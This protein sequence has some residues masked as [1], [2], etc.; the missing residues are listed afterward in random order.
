LFLAPRG[1]RA[2][3]ASCHIGLEQ[4]QAAFAES[5]P[6]L[7]LLR[8]SARHVFGQTVGCDPAPYLLPPMRAHGVTIDFMAKL[9]RQA[10]DA[11]AIDPVQDGT[12][13]NW[14]E[15]HRESLFRAKPPLFGRTKL[16]NALEVRLREAVVAVE[17]TNRVI[18]LSRLVE[19]VRAAAKGTTW[20][21]IEQQRQHSAGVDA[22]VWP[23]A[24]WGFD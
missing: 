12:A 20:E 16:Y 13:A 19:E 23:Y 1:E 7:Q 17:E 9:F 5:G 11:G 10:C 24:V 15:E 2:G 4:D 21:V 14:F 8:D 18:G 6:E 22:K 3:V